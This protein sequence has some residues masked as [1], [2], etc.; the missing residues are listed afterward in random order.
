MYLHVL[1]KLL[2]RIGGVMVSVL[3]SSV[4]D[5]GFEPRSG[6]TK[7]YKEIGMCCFSAKHA[8]LRRKSK[9]WLARNQDSISELGDMSIRR[10]LF[11]WTSTIKKV[12]SSST[13]RTS[14]SFHWN[15]TCSR[16]YMAEQI[17]E[18]ALNNNQSLKRLIYICILSVFLQNDIVKHLWWAE[19]DDFLYMQVILILYSTIQKHLSLIWHLTDSKHE[20]L[21]LLWHLAWNCLEVERRHFANR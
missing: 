9:D 11:H 15:L 14:S 3:D 2:N 4:V 19:N 13:K 5:R 10:L 8:A 12:C 16:L 21:L 1:I 6:Q 7:D 17:A 18:L 20:E